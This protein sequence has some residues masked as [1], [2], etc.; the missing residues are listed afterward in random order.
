MSGLKEHGEALGL[1]AR[2]LPFSAVDGPGNRAVFFLQGCNFDC[3]YCHNPETRAA[4][5]G[6]G[7]CIPACPAGALSPME[8]RGARTIPVQWD[9]ARCRDCGACAASC[10]S[11]SSPRA[12]LVT[13]TEALDEIASARPFLRGITVSGGECTLQSDFLVALLK[14]ARNLGLPGL[15]DT[16]GGRPLAAEPRLLEAAEGF[17]LDVKAWNED[18]HRRLTGADNGPVRD[19]LAFL[20][21]R[22]ALYEVRTVITLRAPGFNAKPAESDTTSDDPQEG[23]FDLE[24]TVR[25]TALTLARAGSRARYRLIRYRPYGVRHERAALLR[26]PGSA[27]MA[28]LTELARRGGAAEVIVS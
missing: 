17:M 2:I 1:L 26:E 7:A 25:E 5:T 22:G 3:A 9:R 28:R 19:N 27:L 4:C 11:G 10:P 18:E 15:V 24:E 21:A 23:A 14:G 20:A 13:P 6:C 8:R 16:N 12:R